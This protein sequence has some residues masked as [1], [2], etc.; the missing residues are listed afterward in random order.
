MCEDGQ[1]VQ[2]LLLVD[3]DGKT[4]LFARNAVSESEFA[5]AVFSPDAATLFVCI[6]DQGHTFAIS[7][8]F[9]RLRP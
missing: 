9:G 8:P 7:G 4:S 6:Q 3:D 5:G 1:G 2:H